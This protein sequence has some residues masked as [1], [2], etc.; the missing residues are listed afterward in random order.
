[1][2]R[3]RLA[4]VALFVI[5]SPSLTSAADAP[6]A[7]PRALESVSRVRNSAVRGAGASVTVDLSGVVVHLDASSR[8]AFV[9]D[10]TGTVAVTGLTADDASKAL[11]GAR[12]QL[13]GILVA[14]D[15]APEVQLIRLTNLG[16]GRMPTAEPLAWNGVLSG[17]QQH[18]WVEVSGIGRTA[19]VV[20]HGVEL[21]VATDFGTVRVLIA[22]AALPDTTTLLDA[23]LTVRGICEVVANERRQI[24]GFRV[25]VPSRQHLEIVEPGAFDPFSLT[26]REVRSL[27]GGAAT[28]HFGRRVRVRGV[29]TLARSGGD[30][31]VHDGRLPVFTRS[32]AASSAL[33]VGQLVDVVGF[34]GSLDGLM[35]EDSVYRVLGEQTPPAPKRTTVAAVMKGG[36]GDELIEIDGELAAIARYADEHVFT[37]MAD[38]AVFYGHLENLA[39]PDIEPGSRV[40]VVGVCVESLDEDGKA[41]VVQGAPAVRRRH[42]RAGRGASGGRSDTRSGCWPRWRSSWS[43]RSAGHGAAPQVRRQTREPRGG[44]RGGGGG[45]PREERVPGQHEPRDPH[46]DERHHRHDR[47]RARHAARRRS[48]ASTSAMVKSSAESLLTVINDILDFSK[49]EAGK[50][51]L[52]HVPFGLRTDGGRRRCGRC[53]SARTQKGLELLCRVAPD[54]PGRSRRRPGPPAP[55]PRQPGRQRDQ[56]HRARRGGRSTCELERRSP[57]DVGLALPAS[58]TPA[59]ASRPRSSATSSRRSRRPTARRRAGT[60]APGSGWRSRRGSSR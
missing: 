24:T 60:A 57:G 42:D 2:P 13:S 36:M 8:T 15:F 12:V 59:S 48:S 22:S 55:G 54:V 28:S 3:L 29:V 17:R 18:Q 58:A 37:L 20:K 40:R 26:L 19:D 23:R 6:A 11:V 45:Q 44:A 43:G 1:M 16:Q 46:A 9:N 34:V 32:A 31:F 21:R 56:V 33:R 27:T 50:L 25:T 39:P 49:I 41:G 53:R 51:E 38:G 30:V 52:E 5:A 4:F 7:E 10:G 14:G 35:L 47:A